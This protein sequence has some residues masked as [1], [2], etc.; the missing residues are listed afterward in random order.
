MTGLSCPPTQLW[1]YDGPVVPLSQGRRNTVFATTERSPPLVFKSSRQSDEA[2]AWLVPVLR[3]AEAAGFVV[4]YPQRSTSGAYVTGGWTCEPFIEG[5]EA[6]TED[7]AGLEA[8]L[9]VF[10]QATG[11]I[12]Q[13]PGFLSAVAL[14]IKRRGGDVDLHAMPSQLVSLCRAAWQTIAARAQTVIHG[15]LCAAN[16]LRT[17]NG[18]I[19]LLDWDEARRDVADFDLIRVAA[20]DHDMQVAH[21]AW[22]VACS[23]TIEPEYARR[24]AGKLVA[25][26][27]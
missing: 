12:A 19:A 21:L 8:G 2:V 13:R 7:L 3:A 24:S 4:P 25:L 27:R 26:M 1:G 14:L 5:S 10:H 6:R 20:P 15:D 17:P 23:W 22:E 11:D 16:V 9:G 18:A